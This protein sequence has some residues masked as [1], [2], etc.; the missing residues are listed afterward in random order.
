MIADLS[1]PI[2]AGRRY[3]LTFRV[4]GPAWGTTWIADR[5]KERVW[6][7]LEGRGLRLL[8]WQVDGERVIVDFDA[9]APGGAKLAPLVLGVIVVGVAGVALLLALS[10]SLDQA[11]E[12]VIAG[13]GPALTFAALAGLAGLALGAWWLFRKGA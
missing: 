1:T 9:G 5:L 2:L 8:S 6:D 4:R 3:R 11:E 12:L 7:E 13:G 10:V